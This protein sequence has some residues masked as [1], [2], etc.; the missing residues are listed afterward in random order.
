M[1]QRSE[2]AVGLYCHRGDL[3]F[4]TGWTYGSRREPEY[5]RMVAV[6]SWA[7]LVQHILEVLWQKIHPCHVDTTQLKRDHRSREGGGW[8][9][10]PRIESDGPVTASKP[11]RPEG[12]ASLDAAQASGVLDAAAIATCPVVCPSFNSFLERMLRSSSVCCCVYDI[13]YSHFSDSVLTGQ[14]TEVETRNMP[15]HHAY[16][17]PTWSAWRSFHRRVLVGKL[18][19]FER[20]HLQFGL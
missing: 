20:L 13:L 12:V 11:I 7:F 16:M 1:L 3:F 10:P 6:T 8:A 4:A 14:Y 19:K 5:N 17:V 18:A 9:P 15:S 2:E